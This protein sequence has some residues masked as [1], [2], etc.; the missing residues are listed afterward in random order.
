[1]RDSSAVNFPPHAFG[2]Q[3]GLPGG[4]AT[5]FLLGLIIFRFSLQVLSL[6]AVL[7]APYPEFDSFLTSL[8]V[9]GI[10]FS[11]LFFVGSF[12]GIILKK[13]WSSKLGIFAIIIGSPFSFLYG[14]ISAI[15]TNINIDKP[16]VM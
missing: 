10:S 14:L 7:V 13:A 16:G 5:L 1:M 9:V 11:L 12:F 6:R 15:N 2:S 4:W 3:G 8:F